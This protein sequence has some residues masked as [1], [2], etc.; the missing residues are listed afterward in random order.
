MVGGTVT[1]GAV[2]GGGAVVGAGAV[3]CSCVVVS[4]S[5]VVVG[6]GGSLSSVGGALV[7]V[8]TGTE[9]D[10]VVGSS[11]LELSAVARNAAPIPAKREQAR[12]LQRSRASG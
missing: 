12:L 3:V 7:P 5:V 6:G 9:S 2:V 11:V 4:G 8:G 10:P 1:V